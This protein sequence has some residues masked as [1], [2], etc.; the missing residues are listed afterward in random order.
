MIYS[1]HLIPR[2]EDAP[3]FWDTKGK[4]P[5]NRQPIVKLSGE[6][7]VTL[8]VSPSHITTSNYGSSQV[9]VTWTG[10][11]MAKSGD[12]IGMYSPSTSPDNDYVD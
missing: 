5:L 6:S 8:T 1:K 10:A 4:K 2:H 7:T 12:W 3:Y 11:T 9:N